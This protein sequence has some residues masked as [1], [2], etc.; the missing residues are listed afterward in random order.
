MFVNKRFVQSG[1][2]TR[3]DTSCSDDAAVVDRSL[4]FPGV[5][6][7]FF[8]PPHRVGKNVSSENNVIDAIHLLE[9]MDDLERGS[10]VK[11]Y[12]VC[13]CDEADGCKSW[14]A[15]SS[16]GSALFDSL[17]SAARPTMVDV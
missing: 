9:E 17:C 1:A 4:V 5:P 3:A 16:G 10:E 2:R 7:V 15:V 6:S 12:Q 11:I 13:L 14:H 8:L